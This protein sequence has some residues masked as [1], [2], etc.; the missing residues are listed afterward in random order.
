MLGVQTLDRFMTGEHPR[1]PRRDR[2]REALRAHAPR[3]R[4]GLR[5]SVFRRQGGARIAISCLTDHSK[6]ALGLTAQPQVK[7]QLG[8]SGPGS[9]AGL[10]GLASDLLPM[11][12]VVKGGVE[13]RSVLERVRPAVYATMEALRPVA[14]PPPPPAEA[15][16]L[17][18]RRRAA[19][20]AVPDAAAV[21]MAVVAQAEQEKL[22]LVVEALQNEE[23]NKLR[24]ADKHPGEFSDTRPLGPQ[25]HLGKL[26]AKQ[27]V[28][29][30]EY[31]GLGTAYGP[32]P[33]TT[34][35]NHIGANPFEGL[36]EAIKH[37]VRLASGTARDY[38]NT[39]AHQVGAT[40]SNPWH[41]PPPPSPQL[42]RFVSCTI[43]CCAQSFDLLHF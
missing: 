14:A 9:K 5:S 34:L 12:R 43:Y 40:A 36:A 2:S 6:A 35:R 19:E 18:R 8:V 13:L 16:P 21:R 31:F 38:V 27:K 29:A 32:V 42:A 7:N 41:P 24:P 10:A 17:K 4:R 25:L 37:A 3:A 1:M 11:A 26:S 15:P 20:P 28:L 22:T 30:F 39:H 23:A 33:E